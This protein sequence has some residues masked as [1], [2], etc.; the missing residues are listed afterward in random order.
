MTKKIKFGGINFGG[1]P[2][3]EFFPPP[4]GNNKRSNRPPKQTVGMK[5]IRSFFT[6]TPAP[7]EKR[8]YTRTNIVEID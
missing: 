7:K 6:Q 3:N 1:R 4:L 5:D 2:N 8:A